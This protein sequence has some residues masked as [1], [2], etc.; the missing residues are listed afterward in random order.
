MCLTNET[1]AVVTDELWIGLNDRKQEGLFD[2]IDHSTVLFTSWE[3]GSPKSSGAN[4]DCVLIK[5]EVRSHF[6]NG[7]ICFST[8]L[9][10]LDLFSIN[11]R[12]VVSLRHDSRFRYVTQ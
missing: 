7:V 12:V 5:G 8:P 4:E 11:P 3:K 9:H 10:N 6:K 1:S 2:W